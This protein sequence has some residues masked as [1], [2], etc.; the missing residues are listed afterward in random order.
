M[1]LYWRIKSSHLVRNNQHMILFYSFFFFWNWIMQRKW[2]SP[3]LTP[4]EMRSFCRLRE[5]SRLLPTRRGSSSSRLAATGELMW[6][7]WSAAW[8][9]LDALAS[10]EWSSVSAL[11]FLPQGNTTSKSFWSSESFKSQARAPARLS[12]YSDRFARRQ[13]QRPYSRE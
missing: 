7:N 2:P 13:R 8:T 4:N 10:M 1:T 6:C 9:K 12:S 11:C 5:D 3:P